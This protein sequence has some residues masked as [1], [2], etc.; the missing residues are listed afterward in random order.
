M[1]QLVEFPPGNVAARWRDTYCVNG[2]WEWDDKLA[3]YERLVELGESPSVDQVNEVIGN[4]SWTQ[5]YC[6]SC[7]STV[8]RAVLFHED[9]GY[10]CKN[11][12][13]HAFTLFSP[14]A[15]GVWHKCEPVKFVNGRPA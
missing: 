14:K 7:E 12:V 5:C 9:D 1:I 8:R 6:C 15:E 3:I 4:P 13:A 10:V 11:C 2:V